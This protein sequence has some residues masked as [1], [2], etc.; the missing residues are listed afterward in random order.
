MIDIII[1]TY[2]RA[3]RLDDIVAN[4][5]AATS[6]PYRLIFVIEEDDLP[7]I[8]VVRTW[9][10]RDWPVLVIANRRCRTYAGAINWAYMSDIARS[11][12]LFAGAD[13]LRFHAGWDTAALS[14]MGACGGRVE[15][16]GT[17]DLLNPYVAQGFHA[18]HYLVAR[19]YLDR[20]GGVVDAGPGSFLPENYDHQF[21][22]TEFIGTAKMRARFMPCMESIVEHL[23]F[24]AGKSDKDATYERAYE[25]LELDEKV[26]QARRDLWFGIS[27]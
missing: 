9:E 19:D 3:G 18:T 4:V 2:G 11:D 7:T 23:H 24:L 27:R 16:V 5:M 13:D 22:D 21:T 15:V 25:Q 1:P 20:D 12:Y 26:Y 10:G 6:T 14:V 17:N 8:D